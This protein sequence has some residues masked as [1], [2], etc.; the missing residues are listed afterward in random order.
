MILN[1][2]YSGSLQVD[3]N[4]VSFQYFGEDESKPQYISG[5]EWSNLTINERGE[6]ILESLA[7]AIS[8]SIDVQHEQIDITIENENEDF[9]EKYIHFPE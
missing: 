6:Y 4:N 7:K 2:D 1:I 8:D 3:A 9:M 5:V